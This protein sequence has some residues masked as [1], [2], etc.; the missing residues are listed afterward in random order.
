MINYIYGML[1]GQIPD[2][3]LPPSP[4]R[5]HCGMHC[6][7][8]DRSCGGLEARTDALTELQ[9]R[10]HTNAQVGA[11]S[12]S[13]KLQLQLFNTTN[14]NTFTPIAR[15]RHGAPRQPARDTLAALPPLILLSPAAGPPRSRLHYHTMPHPSGRAPAGATPVCDRTCERHSGPL[16]A[17]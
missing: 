5:L 8:L 11:E 4:C 16:L 1:F 9:T 17:D 13:S 12:W 15:L 6:G 14:T 2:L 10:P 3:I 7:I